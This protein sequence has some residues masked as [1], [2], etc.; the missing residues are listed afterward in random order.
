MVT[1]PSCFVFTRCM[2]DGRVVFMLPFLDHIIAGTTDNGCD[3][4]DRPVPTK[5]DV[6]FIL[7][8]ISSF[9]S[10]KV[11]IWCWYVLQCP[12]QKPSDWHG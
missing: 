8:A 9:L 7:D 1:A 11:G 10:I 5:E 12:R 4:T 2:Q 3:V 6:A